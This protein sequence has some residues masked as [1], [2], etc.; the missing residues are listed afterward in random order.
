MFPLRA[1]VIRTRKATK[2]CSDEVL[3]YYS[4]PGSDQAPHS[5]NLR[6][7]VSFLIYRFCL[8]NVASRIEPD[9]L[10]SSGCSLHAKLNQAN[11]LLAVVSYLPYTCESSPL[12]LNKT[13]FTCVC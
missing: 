7:D 2:A 4:T 12:S 11:W 3:S 8:V 6:R 13:A 5:P 9:S 10:F 1:A